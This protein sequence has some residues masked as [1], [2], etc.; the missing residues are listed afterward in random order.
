MTDRVER[1][2]DGTEGP[3]ISRSEKPA[4]AG[5][6]S[7]SC[8]STL[9]RRCLA[10]DP[11]QQY[12]LFTPSLI[13]PETPILVAVHGISHAAADPVRRFAPLAE[14]A[15]AVVVA[16]VFARVR[17]PDYQRL[18]SSERGLRADQALDEILRDVRSLHPGCASRMRLFG[19]AGG[20]Q[21]AH[22]YV[23]ARPT[24]VER[25][26]VSAAG[27]YTLPDARLSF[28]FGIGPTAELQGLAPDPRAFLSVPGCVFVGTH[29]T[30]R[31]RALHKAERVDAEPGSARIDRG[32]RWAALMNRAA[33][34]LGLSPPIRFSVLR[35]GGHL[36][37][38]AVRRD[39]LA[40]AAFDFLF[41]SGKDRGTVNRPNTATQS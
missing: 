22:R 3:W 41:G 2:I 21:F 18:G 20:G 37:N 5:D 8:G 9:E 25:Y 40:T 12:Y 28:P 33:T 30:H 17:F 13:P 1:R 36:L 39:G 35:D 32:R 31:G 26:A 14:A 34:S 27:S 23:M 4:G 15:G 38:G 24:E 19:Q 7:A 16:P 10:A 6:P 11:A 29:D